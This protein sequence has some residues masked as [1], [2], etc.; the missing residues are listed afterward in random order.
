MGWDDGIPFFGVDEE[1]IRQEKGK[2]RELRKSRWWRN[3]I[4]EGKCHY[5]GRKVEPPL[6]TMDHVVPM[7]RGGCSQKI[8]IVACCKDC[9]TKKK[10][11][12]PQE[13]QEYMDG[14]EKN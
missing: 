10:S 6:L 12:L 13:W 4:A 3:K 2:A 11:M 7:A 9:N 8:N 14:L 5:C 1:F